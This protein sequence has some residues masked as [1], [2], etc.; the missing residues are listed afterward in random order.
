MVLGIGRNRGGAFDLK[1]YV[2]SKVAGNLRWRRSAKAEKERAIKQVTAGRE[3]EVPYDD[4]LSFLSFAC[5]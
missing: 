4:S 1:P 3:V 2:E 5:L